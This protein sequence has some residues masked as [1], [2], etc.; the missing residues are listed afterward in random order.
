VL[1]AAGGV[2]LTGSAWPDIVVGLTIAGLFMSSAVE[3][4]RAARAELRGAAA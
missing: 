1:A 3:V 4:L 2:A